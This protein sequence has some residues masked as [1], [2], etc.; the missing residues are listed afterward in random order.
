MSSRT[1]LNDNIND[2]YEFTV[3][4]LDYDFKYPTLS[5]VE[6]ITNLYK[7]REIAEKDTSAEGVEKLAQIDERLTDNLYNL[8]IPVGHDV[9]IKETLKKQSVKVVA[10]FN[11]MLAEQLSAE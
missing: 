2:K 5:E 3:G 6:P 1:N 4:G 9:P 8:I 11:K 7:E 10:A